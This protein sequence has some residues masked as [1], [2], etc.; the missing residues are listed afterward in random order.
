MRRAERACDSPEFMTAMFNEVEVMTVA[1][2]G[3]EHPYPVPLNFV[4]IDGSLYFHCALQGRKLDCLAHDSRVGFSLFR[5]LGIDRENAT[6]C[7]QSV[8]GTGTAELV[9]DH[10]LKQRALAALAEK[11]ES[12]CTLPVPEKMLA[13]TAVVRIVITSLSGKRHDRNDQKN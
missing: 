5:F 3:G 8:C 4:H 12:K 11:Y 9:T 2:H 7:Y 10:S 6:T 1:F 13:A